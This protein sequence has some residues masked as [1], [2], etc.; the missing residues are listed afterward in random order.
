MLRKAKFLAVVSFVLLIPFNLLYPNETT[1][2]KS[3]QQ[4]YQSEEVIF[5]R[6]SDTPVGT[7]DPASARRPLSIEIVENL[8]L[9]LT[10]I[11]PITQR[12]VPEMAEDWLVSSDGLIWAFHLR[13]DVYWVHYDSTTESVEKVRL[14]VAADFA[15]SIK[16][17][18]DPRSHNYLEQFLGKFIQGCDTVAQIPFQ[19]ATNEMVFGDTIQVNAIDDTTLTIALHSPAAYFPAI[20]SLSFLHA[21]PQDIIEQYGTD[22]T[23]SSTILT[24]GPYFPIETYRFYRNPYLPS[25][26]F[27]GNGNIA[28]VS[29]TTFQNPPPDIWVMKDD[30]FDMISLS[31]NLLE[32]IE[33]TPDATEVLEQVVSLRDPV[34]HYFA[35]NYNQPPFDNAHVRRAF[36]SII[37]RDLL[38]EQAL[39]GLGILIADFDPIATLQTPENG[40]HFDPDYARAELAEAGYP[41]CSN[42]PPIIITTIEEDMALVDFW[43]A[44]AVDHLGCNAD[45]F[46]TQIYHQ[47]YVPNRP[48]QQPHVWVSWWQ[49]LYP[50]PNAF[51]NERFSCTTSSFGATERFDLSLTGLCRVDDE[52]CIQTR[53]IRRPCT[54]ADSFLQTASVEHDPSIRRLLYDQAETLFWGNEGEYPAVPLF[55]HSRDAIIRPWVRGPF[56]TDSIFGAMH[57][58]SYSIDTTLKAA[59]QP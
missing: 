11:D 56:A 18:C 5:R 26:L 47:D 2:L 29:Q 51:L 19:S 10:D 59:S 15:Y 36:S 34:I 27:R 30:R 35:F 41:N 57:W 43:I 58:D 3:S 46:K 21:Q 6:G 14:V 53:A 22:W 55:L 13:D 45:L 4:S 52:T 24:N 38:V 25:D 23:Q 1:S 12:V 9:G 48:Y 37:D 31:K 17:A 20:S 50:D 44:S 42:F 33:T 49:A 8:F 16:R 7:I 40:A 39:G 32:S 28:M 54:E